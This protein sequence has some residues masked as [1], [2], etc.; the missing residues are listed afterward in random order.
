MALQGRT[1]FIPQGASVAPRPPRRTF[2]VFT[3]IGVLIFIASLVGLGASIL[4]EKQLNEQIVQLDDLI[5]S[6]E[7][8]FNRNSLEE[9]ARVDQK[10]SAAREILAKH[11]SLQLLFDLIDKHTLHTI[12]FTSFGFEK[13]PENG[14]ILTLTGVGRDYASIALQSD[15]F[16]QTRRLKDVV[17]SNLR[18][19]QEGTITFG[20][21]ATIDE[22]LLEYGLTLSI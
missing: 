5:R 17:F 8:A 2:G 21:T 9:I 4:Y 16:V 7:D 13:H 1:A 22:K 12:R 18:L 14:Y 10:I 15:A 11:T 19:T 6:S 20:M 3:A